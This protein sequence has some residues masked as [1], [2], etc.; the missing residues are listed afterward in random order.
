M[1]F[2][3]AWIFS[4]FA[5]SADGVDDARSVHQPTS[6]L[7]S[8]KKTTGDQAQSSVTRLLQQFGK[9]PGLSANFREEK[10][11]A[12]LAAPLINEGTIHFAQ[13]K[14]VRHTLKPTVS[15]VL[16]SEGKLQFFD[17]TITK[18]L[19]VDSHPLLRHYVATFAMIFGGDYTGLAKNYRIQV[20]EEQS[21][22]TMIFEPRHP[23]V[24]K[25]ISKIVLKGRE[26]ML[27]EMSIVEVS[28]DVTFTRFST[29]RVDRSYTSK[30]MQQIFRVGP[31]R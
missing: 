12:L 3:A 26:L 17:G 27:A 10:R 5:W 13:G 1:K 22:W 29:V 6:R 21:L 20:S 8:S 4:L 31:T 30:E 28:G 15:S 7:K 23:K 19:D 2:V 11:M 9:M 18:S 14:L 25:I 16:V 24:A